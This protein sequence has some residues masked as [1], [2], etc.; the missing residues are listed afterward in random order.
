MKIHYLIAYDI[1]EPKRLNRVHYF[2]SKKATALQRSVFLVKANQSDIKSITGG[3]L[4]R[5]DTQVDDIRLYP[6]QSVDKIWVAG[7]QAEKMSGLY[8]SFSK[9]Q[10]PS[11]TSRFINRLFGAKK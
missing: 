9:K 3:L 5:A 11:L 8:P 1:R 6:L 4:E 10:K 2:I 7:K